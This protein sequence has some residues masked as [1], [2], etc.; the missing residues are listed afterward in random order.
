MTVKVNIGRC[1]CGAM[2][3]V[4]YAQQIVRDETGRVRE[5]WMAMVCCV[6]CGKE[7]RA[8]A[9]RITDFVLTIEAETTGEEEDHEE[10]QDVLPDQPRG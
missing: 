4:T 1:A 5:G 2:E 9:E 6:F 3:T 10:D 8:Y 7:R